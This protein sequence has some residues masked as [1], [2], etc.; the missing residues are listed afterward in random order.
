VPEVKGDFCLVLHTHLPYVLAHGRW[1]HG[2]DWINEAA[3]ECYIP[4]LDMF[5]R[6]SDQG[7]APKI[8]MGITPILMEQLSDHSFAEEFREY[9]GM[10]IKAAEENE[11]E[12][13]ESG[14]RDMAELAY[15]W[16]EYYSWIWRKF[17]EYGRDLVRPFKELQ[18]KGDIE[19]ITSAATHGYLPLLLR[20]E[21]VRAQI[22]EGIRCYEEHCGRRPRGIWLPECG[23]RPGYRW[24]PP[25]ESIGN[26]GYYDRKGIEEFLSESGIEYFVIDTHMLKGGEAIG[27]YLE[28]FEALR[29]LWKDF[30][31]S[32]EPLPLDFEKSPYEL[33]LV[34]ASEGKAPVAVFTRDPVTGIQVW[35]GEHGY[36]GDGWYLDFHKKHFPGGLRYWRVTSSKSDLADKEIYRPEKVEERISENA[37]HFI[38]LVEG[39]LSENFEAKG[40]RG[41][42]CAPYDSEL[43]GHWWFEGP[44]WL[45]KVITGLYRRGI[46][47]PTT[48]SEHLDRARPKIVISLPEGS[49]GQGGFHWIWLNEWTYWTWR[50]IYD[51]ERRMI[52]LADGAGQNDDLLQ[53]IL[54]QCARELLLLESSDWQFLISTWTA[55]DYAELRVDE[56]Y[57]AFRKLDEMARR[58]MK[59]EEISEEEIAFLKLCEDRDRPFKDIDPGLWRSGI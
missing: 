12:F 48:C 47:E 10:K 3:A 26:E 58:R 2:M 13:R 25:L 17:M 29:R 44:R 41:V 31:K 14:Q 32:Y 36:P 28:R 16:R 5:W 9:V 52:E 7:I 11:K 23:Y 21:C 59:G 30:E 56:H 39:I 8:T 19:I 27:T 46:V 43:F 22:V 1:P 4:L 18:D 15:M 51:A 57:R 6:L 50:H 34:G 45:E 20:D 53:R 49:W 40:E 35:S 33:Y 38:S 24:R 37:D 42:L 54:R 55:R